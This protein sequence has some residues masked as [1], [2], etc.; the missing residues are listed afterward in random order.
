MPSFGFILMFVTNTKI[1][2]IITLIVV[3]LLFSIATI[4]C[5]TR[6]INYIYFDRYYHQYSDFFIMY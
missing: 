2:F 5:F 1:I 6:N 4:F 3:L